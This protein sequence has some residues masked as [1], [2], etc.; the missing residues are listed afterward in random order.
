[1]HLG[2]SAKEHYNEKRSLG[3]MQ[4]TYMNYQ[5]T[6]ESD[7]IRDHH[8]GKT[9]SNKHTKRFIAALKH[10]Q[11]LLGTEIAH[12]MVKFKEVLNDKI[13]AMFKYKVAHSKRV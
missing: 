5:S 1:V 3:L 7:H 12:F 13:K 10:F 6:G 11:K 4:N 9:I 8:H 2:L